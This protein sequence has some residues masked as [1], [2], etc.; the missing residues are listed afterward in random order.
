MTKIYIYDLETLGVNETAVVL[1]IG[2]I[3]IDSMEP[4]T[5]RDLMKNSFFVKLDAKYQIEKLNRQVTSSTIEWWGK[6]SNAAKIRSYKP[7]KDDV[8]PEVALQQLRQFVYD[9]TKQSRVKCYTRGSMDVIVSE[10]LAKQV[11]IKLPWV[12]N[13]FRD[14]RTAV[15]ILYP[16]SKDGYVAVDQTKCFGYTDDMTIA[17]DPVHDCARDAAMILF[18]KTE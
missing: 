3:Y 10:H 2:C 1:S 16:L 18:G 5:Y 11:D 4:C 8:T 9:N 17:H 14:V 13:D 12:Y 7:S 6:Q 15:D